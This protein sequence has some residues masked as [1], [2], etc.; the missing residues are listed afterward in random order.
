MRAYFFGLIEVI[1]A[2]TGL[3]QFTCVYQTTHLGF[4]TSEVK[5]DKFFLMDQL[6]QGWLALT[7][8]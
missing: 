6:L 1:A 3:F 5:N 8:R 2:F 4:T 7:I